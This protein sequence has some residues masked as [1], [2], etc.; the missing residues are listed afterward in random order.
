MAYTKARDAG[1]LAR[2]RGRCQLQDG[3]LE[4]LGMEEVEDVGARQL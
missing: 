3:P 4:I 2:P 1:A